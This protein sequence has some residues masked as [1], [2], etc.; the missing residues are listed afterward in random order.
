[1]TDY[2]VMSQEAF[3]LLNSA[4]L[5]LVER[6]RKLESGR[7][8]CAV[9]K[10]RRTCYWCG[11]DTSGMDPL[12]VIAHTMECQKSPIVRDRDE[13]REAAVSHLD[14]LWEAKDTL[15]DYLAADE[16]DECCAGDVNEAL[17]DEDDGPEVED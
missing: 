11:L 13:W 15:D 17:W 4:V 2:V 1:M 16:D 12:Q 14:A 10:C 7:S 6:N 9:P 5:R 3:D 8:T